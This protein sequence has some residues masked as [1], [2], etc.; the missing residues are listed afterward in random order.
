MPSAPTAPTEVA[1]LA[2][3]IIGTQNIDDVEMPGDDRIAATMNRWYSVSR[4]KCL[5][6]FPWNFASTRGT[7]P[8]VDP[9]PSF[10]Y[11]DAYTL[12]NDFV[13]LNFIEDESLPLS[14]YDYTIENGI[15][16]IDNGGG[17]SLKIGYVRDT[18]DVAKYPASFIMFLAHVLASNT[19]WIL[20]KNATIAN[21]VKALEKPARL[22]AQA[23]NGL[24]N[25]PRAYRSSAM[26]RARKRYTSG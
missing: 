3:D 5:E 11:P 14:E 24:N 6:G 22:E 20:T 4:R 21:A 19:V 18:D 15:I 2:I 9:A 17:E 16:L 10:G 1:N 25:P 12:P 8:L 13:S 7:I 26:L 23:A